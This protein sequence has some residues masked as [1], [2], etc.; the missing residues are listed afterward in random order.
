MRDPRI[1]SNIGGIYVPVL[2]GILL[3]GGSKG[4]AI[5]GATKRVKDRDNSK[6]KILSLTAVIKN[7]QLWSVR[8][9]IMCVYR[10]VVILSL[11]GQVQ[12]HRDDAT[13]IITILFAFFVL[14]WH[15]NVPAMFVFRKTFLY[16]TELSLSLSFSHSF[17]C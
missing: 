17:N 1:N 2:S 6:I 5:S 10:I 11:I 7:K 15:R 9:L 14:D 4:W 12:S 16:I 13:I 8:I 3:A